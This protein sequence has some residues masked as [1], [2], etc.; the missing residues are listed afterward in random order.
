MKSV[1]FVLSVVLL[2]LCTVAFAQSDMQKSDAQKSFDKMKT[3]AGT[4][5]GH[6]TTIPQR[7]EIEGKLVQA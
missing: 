4:W 6:V 1:S 5:E 3:L 2:P 7:T